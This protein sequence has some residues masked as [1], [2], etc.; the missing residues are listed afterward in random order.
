LTT[1]KYFAGQCWQD[2]P[3]DNALTKGNK[4]FTQEQHMQ[5]WSSLDAEKNKAFKAFEKAE[6]HYDNIS[7]SYEVSMEK[8]MAS[9]MLSTKRAQ[10][11]VTCEMADFYWKNNIEP[12]LSAA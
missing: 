11:A 5:I 10:Y 12:M 8:E 9:V 2:L 6:K 1:V 4:M 7:Y 3:I